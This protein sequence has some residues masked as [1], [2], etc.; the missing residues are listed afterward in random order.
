MQRVMAEQH[1]S[2]PPLRP[3]PSPSSLPHY[4]EGERFFPISHEVEALSPLSSHS[5]QGEAEGAWMWV[6][7][8]P[9]SPYERGAGEAGGEKSGEGGGEEDSCRTL[10]VVDTSEAAQGALAKRSSDANE[11]AR[12]R[13]LT[14]LLL[15]SSR[16]VVN[17]ARK[18]LVGGLARRGEETAFPKRPTAQPPLPAASLPSSAITGLSVPP[19]VLL[20]RDAT[21][22][23][24]G[25]NGTR[26]SDE[27]V[28]DLWFNADGERVANVLR[29]SF[30]S[31]ALMML[32]APSE[33]ELELLQDATQPLD[34]SGFGG[35]LAEIAV[36]LSTHMQPLQMGKQSTAEHMEMVARWLNS[37]QRDVLASY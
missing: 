28:L 23:L 7:A 8:A 29:D 26:L 10:V 17:A 4:L 14:F 20:I 33:L 9:S 13:L 31:R 12:R 34:A 32:D 36:N 1:S 22:G 27:E 11:L 18:P 15:T 5:S 6:T 24:K 21:L 3:R 2:S 30:P 35:A 25:K 19:L 37:L 16:L